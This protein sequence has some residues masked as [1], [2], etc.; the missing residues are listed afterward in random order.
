MVGTM[1][2]GLE[3]GP[4]LAVLEDFVNGSAGRMKQVLRGLRSG[5]PIAE[6]GG[7]SSTTLQPGEIGSGEAAMRSLDTQALIDHTHE[8]WFGWS[9]PASGRW[10]PNQAEFD[11]VEN[12]TTGFWS[13]WYG[14]AEGV[15][16]ETMTRALEVCLGLEHG[17]EPSG[18][19]TPRRWYLDGFWSTQTPWFEGWVSWRQHGPKV[20][21][22]QVTMLLSTPGQGTP[23]KNTPLRR[24]EAQDLGYARQPVRST[25]PQGMWVVSQEYHR[26][27]GRSLTEP[28]RAGDWV[29]PN[30]ALRYAS[31]G[32]VVVVSPSEREGGVLEQPR[33]WI[34]QPKEQR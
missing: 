14:D 23:L 5:R 22:G 4:Y 3:K 7:F 24:D 20:R 8:H 19:S 29:Y 12:P 26:Q 9:R 11:I 1:P 21:D 17:E 27:V 28:R 31:E 10:K 32:D 34:R 6:L 30:E 15:L 16:R 18:R 25:S 33:Q 2:I 13:S